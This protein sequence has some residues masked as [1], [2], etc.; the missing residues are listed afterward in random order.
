MKNAKKLP[1]NYSVKNIINSILKDNR[2]AN[3]YSLAQKQK[4]YHKSLK[5]IDAYPGLKKILS[6]NHIHNYPIQGAHFFARLGV[7]P[8]EL[9]I[10]DQ[11]IKDMCT[12]PY[13]TVYKDNKGVTHRKFGK[14]P[15]YGWLPGCPPN[16]PNVEAVQKVLDV[17]DLFIVLQTKLQNERGDTHWKFNVLHRLAYDIEQVL[18]KNSITGKF[19]SGPCNACK[20][21]NCVYNKP[22]S[23]PKL[24]TVSLESMGVCVDRLCSD[25]AALTGQASWKMTWLKHFGFPQQIPK[26]WKYVEAL[27]IKVL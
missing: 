11:R 1:V 13:W 12:L 7:F 24:E 26:K 6:V 9:V 2:K 25:L 4:L 19:G 15:G 21:Q 10:I 16:S 3:R 20:A 23:S 8:S 14:C 18:G 17:S 22:C 5:Y 27:S